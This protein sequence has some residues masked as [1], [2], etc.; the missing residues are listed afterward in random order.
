LRGRP[1]QFRAHSRLN[2]LPRQVV[3]EV[4][5]TVG[6]NP[7][8]VPAPVGLQEPHDRGPESDAVRGQPRPLVIPAKKPTVM[9]ARKPRW[10]VATLGSSFCSTLWVHLLSGR[11]IPSPG[12]Q[13]ALFR[14]AK[15]HHIAIQTWKRPATKLVYSQKA[16]ATATASFQGLGPALRSLMWLIGDFLMYPVAGGQWGRRCG[17][18]DA[19]GRHVFGFLLANDD[20]D[21]SARTSERPAAAREVPSP[22]MRLKRRPTVGVTIPSVPPPS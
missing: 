19:L 22:S 15:N 6:I 17:R 13:R 16:R 8:W 12:R 10:A 14:M 2:K 20:R 4:L 1:N 3:A 5:G 7:E 18:V 11:W 21:P 9:V